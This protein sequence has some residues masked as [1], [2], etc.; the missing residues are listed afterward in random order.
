MVFVLHRGCSIINT[1]GDKAGSKKQDTTLR[2]EDT[3]RFYSRYV[4]EY[5][6][7]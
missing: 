7:K 3:A 1:A 6:I 4:N 5:I 2:P